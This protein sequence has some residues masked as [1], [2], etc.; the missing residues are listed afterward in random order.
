[1][2]RCGCREMAFHAMPDLTRILANCRNGDGFAA[3]TQMSTIRRLTAAPRIK[4]RLRQ[5]GPPVGA[6]KH[7]GVELPLI[8]VF[9]V[10]F[11]SKL[12]H[13]HRSELFCRETGV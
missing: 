12:R 3:Y 5:Y 10:E 4:N 7:I 13:Q 9:E 8:G 2:H 1:M 6:L 11:A